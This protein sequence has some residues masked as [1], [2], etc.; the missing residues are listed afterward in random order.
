MNLQLHYESYRA[1]AS[2]DLLDGVPE[3]SKTV[4]VNGYGNAFTF[5]SAATANIKKA[6]AAKDKATY[7]DWLLGHQKA[8]IG[9]LEK[10]VAATGLEGLDLIEKKGWRWFRFTNKRLFIHGDKP[11]IWIPRYLPSDHACLDVLIDAE[12][13]ESV[14]AKKDPNLAKELY[15]RKAT[16]MCKILPDDVGYD[17]DTINTGEV[18]D[19]TMRLT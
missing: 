3:F 6:I 12:E 10:Y 15:A 2:K 19:W 1:S 9:M 8:F 16:H 14:F 18:R 5:F 7:V 11:M 13:M 4:P 17:L